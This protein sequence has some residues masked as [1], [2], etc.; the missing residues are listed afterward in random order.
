MDAIDKGMPR[1]FAGYSLNKSTRKNSSSG[2]LFFEIGQYIINVL[3]GYVW[4]VISDEKIIEYRCAETIIEL[5]EQ[6]GSKYV[7]A[8]T[9]RLFAGIEEQIKEKKH[10]LVVGTPCVIVAVKKRFGN[11]SY[12]YTIDLVCHG[13]G[14]PKIYNS[15]LDYYSKGNKITRVVFRNKSHGWRRYTI[16]IEGSDGQILHT[17]DVI[18]DEYITLFNENYILRPSCYNCVFANSHREGDV[19]LA[20]FWGYKTA[21]GDELDDDKGISAIIIN[22]DR[23]QFLIDSIKTNVFIEDKTMNDVSLFQ[24]TMKEPSK[25]PMNYNDFWKVYNEKGWECVKLYG[26]RGNKYWE[27]FKLSKLGRFIIMYKLCLKSK[28]IR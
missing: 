14:S 11:Y 25:K 21:K 6:M 16:V 24:R 13:V 3:H 10:I 7:Q 22:N 19:S 27:R 28:K 18:D 2:G 5:K 20:D 23:G 4:G 26:K 12:L 1:V 17:N 9:C 15:Y 8:D